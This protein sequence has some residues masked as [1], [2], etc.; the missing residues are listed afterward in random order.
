MSGSALPGISAVRAC[1][2]GSLGLA[3][4]C[5]RVVARDQ[6]LDYNSHSAMNVM[7]S[8]VRDENRTSML[9]VLGIAAMVSPNTEWL[10]SVVA[11]RP[12]LA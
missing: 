2:S 4:S 1:S 11:E 7:V 9:V 8:E 6:E 10:G 12:Q 5:S 3:D